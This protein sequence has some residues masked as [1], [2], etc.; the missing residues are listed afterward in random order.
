[1]T[2]HII[3]TLGAV[4]VGLIAV[5]Q[6]NLARSQASLDTAGLVLSRESQQALV[7]QYCVFCHDDGE[8]VGDMTLSGLDLDHVGDS[9]PLAEKIIRKLRSGMMPPAGQPRPDGATLNAF[10]ASLETTLDRIAAAKTNPGTRVLQRLNRAEYAR[11][12][13]EL[14]DLDVDV[15]TLLPPDSMDKGFDNIADALTLSPALMEGF[16]RAASKISHLAVGEVAAT[17]T[18]ATYKV[19]RTSSQM[20][21][22]TGAPLGTRG[23]LSVVHTFSGRR[24]I[25]FQDGVLPWECVLRW[26]GRR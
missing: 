20:R 2:K 8:R 10:A 9:A 6:F 15:A 26:E 13:R 16:I 25:C 7:D 1:M 11:S 19:P 14:L 21:Y 17:P 22:V 23:G 4:L 3:A 24:R 12:V 5:T 18:M